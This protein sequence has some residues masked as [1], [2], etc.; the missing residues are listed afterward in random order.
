M[1]MVTSNYLCRIIF[2]F[3]VFISL[4]S[5]KSDSCC[6]LE[7]ECIDESLVDNN[8]DCSAIFQPVCGCDGI[9]YYNEC[10][11]T[12]NHG[13]ITYSD[14]ICPSDCGRSSDCD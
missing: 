14:G 5:C 3:S 7:D 9:T 10:Q 12:L 6:E 11:A 1:Q 4:Y 13:V 8:I 2:I